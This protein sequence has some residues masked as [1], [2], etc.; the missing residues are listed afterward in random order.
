MPHIL[1]DQHAHATE[2]GIEGP[3]P[4]APRHVALFIEQAVGRQ[5]DLAMQVADF[6]RLQIQGGILETVI[7][8]DLNKTD[9]NGNVS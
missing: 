5:V 1:A 3:K 8:R 6:A 2:P 9:Y 4:L 7:F